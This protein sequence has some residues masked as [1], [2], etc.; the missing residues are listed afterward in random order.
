MAQSSSLVLPAPG[1][2]PPKS[3]QKGAGKGCWIH[4]ITQAVGTVTSGAAWALG[5]QG[6]LPMQ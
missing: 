6:C 5:V 4:S 1:G 3:W 2:E